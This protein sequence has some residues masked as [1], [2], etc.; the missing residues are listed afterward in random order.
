MTSSEELVGRMKRSAS[1]DDVCNGHDARA[2]SL[3]PGYILNI[4]QFVISHLV[5]RL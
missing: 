3:V 2:A 4:S 5:T 1:G